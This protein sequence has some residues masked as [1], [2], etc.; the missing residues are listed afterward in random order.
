MET[1]FGLSRFPARIKAFLD[2]PRPSAPATRRGAEHP[3]R[4]LM[5]TSNGVGLGHVTRAMAIGSRL[6][7]GFQPVFFTL[8]RAIRLIREAGFLAESVPF[9]RGI[10]ADPERWND[11]FAE[12][13][14]AALAF[15][16]PRVLIFD[17]NV[18]YRGLTAALAGHPEVFSVW[19][20]R[21]M[22]SPINAGALATADT[23]D[24]V[25]EPCEVAG[26]YDPGPT[27]AE[28]GSVHRVPAHP[29]PRS[30]GPSGP[31]GGAHGAR[32][33]ARGARGRLATRG[34]QQL[35]PRRRS[36]T[37]LAALD[38]VG[39]TVVE[40]VSPVGETVPVPSG[41]RHTVRSTY[42]SS[43][44][45]AAFDFQVSGAGYNSFHEAVAAGLPTVFVPNEAG[46][47][48]FRS[49]AP[50]SP[51]GGPSGS[52][53]RADDP[54][55]AGDVIGF[56]D[57]AI[58]AGMTARAARFAFRNGA[59]DAA[60]FIADLAGFVRADRDTMTPD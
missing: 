4:V 31:G 21:A 46:R 6:P 20:R 3:R 11:I 17:G 58:R 43:P 56:V 36:R 54:Y 10:G 35:R 28:A 45:S 24:A 42:P 41:T 51:T 5:V 9:H 59:A 22:W 23:F 40:F 55:A 38:A 32:D 47:W 2:G 12:E 37:V 30:R 7:A 50:A 29:P 33:R 26:A 19:V 15:Y 14:H 39:A 16:R 44:L 53:L 60:R 18:P 52:L 57:P 48:I 25:I 34:R 1:R 27:V 13:I 8:S 49:C